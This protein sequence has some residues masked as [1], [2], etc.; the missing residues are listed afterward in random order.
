MKVRKWAAPIVLNN[1]RTLTKD[2]FNKDANGWTTFSM[3]TQVANNPFY[4]TEQRGVTFYMLVYSEDITYVDELKVG[5]A[6]EAEV[7]RGNT[8]VYKGRL[9]DYVDK[10]AKDTAAPT[11][12]RNI[13]FENIELKDTMVK[14]DNATDEGSIYNYKIRGIGRNGTTDFSKRFLER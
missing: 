12:P 14:F 3:N 5:Y 9:S 13:R 7:Y 8:Q 1:N 6:S 2:D 4:I 10:E 11:A